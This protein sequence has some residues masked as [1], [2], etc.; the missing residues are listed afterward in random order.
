M[1]VHFMHRKCEDCYQMVIVIG[2]LEFELHRPNHC[3]PSSFD[4][5]VPTNQPQTQHILK[6]TES[7]FFDDNLSVKDNSSSSPVFDMDVPSNIS[8]D[9][10][11]LINLRPKVKITEKPDL[12]KSKPEAKITKKVGV[13]EEAEIVGK[14]KTVESRKTRGRKKSIKKTSETD[15]EK[16]QNANNDSDECAR[17]E[18]DA[19]FQEMCKNSDKKYARKRYATLPKNVP[20]TQEGCDKMFGHQRTL[21]THLKRDH[22]IIEKNICPICNLEL[23]DKSNLKHHM[24]THTDNK[25]FIC[26]FCGARFHKQTN[27]TEHT[28]AHLNLKPYKCEICSKTFGRA[29]HKR[30]HLRVIILNIKIRVFSLQHINSHHF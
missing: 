22:G 1:E 20:C 15:V 4:F 12:I 10:E 24:I 13:V 2:D 28:N 3:K 7:R 16:E 9:D 21:N 14:A 5:S 6:E 19:Y 8:S 26:S 29:N 17:R 18:D 30:Q 23:S 27:L 25:R 11:F